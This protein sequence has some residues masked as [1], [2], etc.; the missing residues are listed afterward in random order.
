MINVSDIV[1]IESNRK[2]IKKELYTKIYEQFC[3]KIKYTVE[4]GGKQVFLRVP[5]VVFGYPTFD[6]THACTYLK[7]QLEL[8]G[9]VVRVISNIDLHV[10]WK[11]PQTSKVGSAHA[12]DEVELPSFINLKKIANKYRK[13]IQ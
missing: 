4:M 9:F 13:D 6:R 7:R 12:H 1:N 5:S 10:T 2:K 8:G 3:R 11:I